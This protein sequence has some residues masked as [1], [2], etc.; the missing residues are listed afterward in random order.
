[1]ILI[2]GAGLTGL[3]AAFH[4]GGRDWR[5]LERES[6]PGG[7]CRTERIGGYLFDYGGHLLHLRGDY[8][9]SL[10]LELLGPRLQL[11]KRRSAILSHGILTPYPFQVNTHGLPPETVADCLAGFLEAKLAA[12]GRPE[13]D[14]FEDWIRY[15][16]GEG[17][18]RNF[19]LPFNRKFFKTD[20]KT[21]T[22]EWA[23]WSIPR[24]SVREVVEGALGISQKE[25]GYNPEFYYPEGGIE[26]LPKALA[27]SLARPV[28][29]GTA[30]TGLV[31]DERRALLSTGEEVRYRRLIAT[32]P[33]P[34]LLLLCAGAPAELKAAAER[35]GCLSVRCRNLGVSGP[36]LTDQHWIYLPEEKYGFH[37]IGVYSNILPQGA[38]K[39]ALYL[40]STVRLGDEAAGDRDERENQGGE[41]E[42]EQLQ[43]SPLWN[44]SHRLEVST[45]MTIPYAYVI[46]DDQRRRLLP[47]IFAWLR[48]RG[49]EPAGRYG[50][51]EYS[52]MED[53]ILEGREA[54]EGCGR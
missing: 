8:V 30:L 33:L 13:P 50:R 46:Y 7:Q 40:E 36:P 26:E 43:A 10:A 51:W 5:L 34:E 2:A 17:F 45:A 25:F 11:H 15:Q 47:R 28:E 38:G 35:L 42:I 9:R 37:R 21:M 54:A 6:R 53:A 14:N 41:A 32:I 18:A 23:Q 4:L 16:F 12:Q 31:P 52:S 44:A 22:T 48:E 3:S 19:F 29:T 27:R 24:P 20:L 1:M 49:I 39:N